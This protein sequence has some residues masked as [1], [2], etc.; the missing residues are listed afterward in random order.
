MISLSTSS[1]VVGFV[2]NFVANILATKLSFLFTDDFGIL[3]EN[4]GSM[5]VVWICPCLPVLQKNQFLSSFTSHKL[6]I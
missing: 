1:F 2:W 4:L 5:D 6:G 3:I